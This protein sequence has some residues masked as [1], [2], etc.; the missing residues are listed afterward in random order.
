MKQKKLAQCCVLTLGLYSGLSQAIENWSVQKQ[1]N[2]PDWLTLKIDHRTRYEGYDS[3]FKKG[4]SGGDQVIAFRTNVFMGI[5]YDNFELGTE[6]LDSRITLEGANTPINNTQ[7]NQTD[8]LQ[9]YLAWQSGDFLGSGL[10]FNIKAGRQTMDVGS[11]RLIA[12]NRFRNT[13]NNFTGFDTLLS[14]GDWELRNFVVLPV[15]RLPSDKASLQAGQTEFDQEDFD[16]IFAGTFFSM[17]NLPLNST[18]ELYGYYL[19]EDDTPE[20]L[21]KNRKLFTPGFRWFK[22]AQSNQFDFEIETALQ[23]GTSYATS[24]AKDQ[25]RLNH[26]AYFSH[27]TLGYSF[28][29]PWQPQLMLQYDYASGDKDPNDNENNQFETLY[30]ARRFEFG[31]TGIWGAFARANINS[32]GIRLK[33]KPHKTLTGLIAHR[34]YWLAQSK[35]SWTGAG[36]RDTTGNSSSYLGQQMEMS[37]KWQAIPQLLDLESGWAHLFKGNFAK[38]APNAPTNKNDADYFYF[39]TSIHI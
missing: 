30:G 29:A 35:D 31:P 9:A 34:A 7:I 16:R 25:Q 17:K 21:T 39:Q 19:S 10:N 33:I 1:L 36:L 32:P 22:K 8:L 26:F 15:S 28:D 2:L 38:N 27:A 14:Q 37:L 18:G 23:T 24:N 13:I 20:T 11:R 6:F 12:R 3:A 5:K 4:T